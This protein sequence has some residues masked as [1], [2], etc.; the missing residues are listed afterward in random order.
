MLCAPGFLLESLVLEP[1]YTILAV[2]GRGT[3]F[4]RALRLGG[5]V[6]DADA[7]IETAVY[8]LGEVDGCAG[9]EADAEFFGHFVAFLALAGCRGG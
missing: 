7:E 2:V 6:G 3:G 9:A 1:T 5:R 4:R 8:G